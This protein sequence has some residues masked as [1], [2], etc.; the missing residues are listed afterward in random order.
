MV[1]LGTKS[2]SSACATSVL[3]CRAISSCVFIFFVMSCCLPCALYTERGTF[4]ILLCRHSPET[5]QDGETTC[6]CSVLWCW[7]ITVCYIEVRAGSQGSQNI[8]KSQNT[9]SACSYPGESV[10]IG[11]TLSSC[12]AHHILLGM[13]CW[14]PH[15][16]S[17][18]AL[19]SLL[20][21]AL[22]LSSAEMSLKQTPS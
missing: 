6:S 17:V 14:R 13:S 15:L 2:G 3:N 18:L 4:S 7:E 10:G 9:V 1:F 8:Q 11:E 20:I 5:E 19:L 12:T 21:S 16:D 22:S